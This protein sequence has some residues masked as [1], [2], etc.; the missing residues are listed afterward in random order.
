MTRLFGRSWPPAAIAV[1]ALVGRP[2]RRRPQARGEDARGR[3]NQPES[4]AFLG[5]NDLLVLEKATGKVQRVVNGAVP[6]HR[7][8]P[9]GEFRLRARPARDRPAPELPDESG[10]LSVLDA[11]HD[12]RRHQRLTETPLLGNR[13]D[14]FVWN[15]STLTFDM[16]LIS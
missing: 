15:G 1:T 9:G 16:N 8:R 3:P 12:P 2:Y 6:V 14:R 4:I 5:A 7:A 13:V 11:E 10:R